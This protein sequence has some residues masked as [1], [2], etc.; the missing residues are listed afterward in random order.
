MSII[1]TTFLLV[2]F[3]ISV[4]FSQSGLIVN[5]VL[6]T[7]QSTLPQAGEYYDWIEI[8]NTTSAAI[9]ISG[10][11]L[12]D[13]PANKTKHKLPVSNSLIVPSNGYL[14]LFANLLLII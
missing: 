11:H 2:F 8:F 1:K 10:Y 7:N 12:T 13:D 5:E 3:S 4:S 14:M 9:N 6:S